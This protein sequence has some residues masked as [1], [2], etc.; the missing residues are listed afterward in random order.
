M[1][2]ITG[3]TGHLGLATIQ[4]LTAKIA[5]SEIVAVVRDPQKAADTLP[6]GVVVRQGDYNDPASLLAAFQGV[7]TVLLISTSE[8]EYEARMRE[9][10]N[11]IDAARQAGVRHLV[12]TSVVNP[13]AESAFG[14]SPGH[15]ATEEYLRASGL[16]YTI[17]RNT[18][19]LD[20]IPML[21]GEGTL[22]SGQLYA[23]AGDGKVSY[24]LR[25]EI[26]EAL[27]NVLAGQGHENQVYDIAPGPAY[28]FQDIAN[29]LSEVTGQPVA[30]VPV[31]GEDIAAGMRQHQVPEPFINLLLGMNQAIKDGEF[32]AA[33]PAFEQLLGRK[34]TGLKTYL[35]GVY[36]K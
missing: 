7:E 25:A 23:S 14:A 34:P 17:L 12:Y 32:D 19:Y 21:V 30:Y 33:S 24:A 11:V 3:A 1:I 6:Q 18:L 35:A 16:T 27:A 36:G 2:A 5:P 10:K 15:F 8:L 9:H 13:S 26:G 28:S 4:A 31:S 20:I 22:P 29:G